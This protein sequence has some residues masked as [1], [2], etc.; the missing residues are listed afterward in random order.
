MSGIPPRNGCQEHGARKAAWPNDRARASGNNA[1]PYLKLGWCSRLSLSDVTAGN[2]RH[3]VGN[4]AAASCRPLRRPE[5]L[6]P[7]PKDWALPLRRFNSRHGIQAK[8]PAHVSEFPGIGKTPI[9]HHF[10]Q[11]GNP[12]LGKEQSW[13]ALAGIK[14]H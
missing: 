7:T 9:T 11:F 5:R 10:A 6:G 14:P 12:C 1:S 8:L 13:Q 2:R 4:H 3:A